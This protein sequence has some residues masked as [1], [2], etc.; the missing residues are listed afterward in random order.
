MMM[1][2]IGKILVAADS[3]QQLGLRRRSIFLEF[4]PRRTRRLLYTLL[5]Y[6]LDMDLQPAR[7]TLG[8][9]CRLA[10]AGMT[11]QFNS[12]ISYRRLVI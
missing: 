11:L 5:F 4:E 12:V 8:S 3:S 6:R 9:V 7:Q 1:I 2:L 10:L